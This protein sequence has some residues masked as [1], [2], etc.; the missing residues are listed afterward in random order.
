ME[1][2]IPI[3]QFDASN[4]KWGQPRPGPLRKT[5]TFSYE[6][7]KISFN[8][9]IVTLPPLRVVEVDME[10]NQ[11]ILEESNNNLLARLEQLQLKVNSELEEK[12]KQWLKDTK[13]PAVVKCPL[14]PWVKSNRITLYLSD[15]PE[16]LCFYT[17]E[18]NSVF[19]DKTVK[20]G[21]MILSTVKIHG[22]SLQM[23]DNDL[24]TG[25]SRIQHQILQLYKLSP[26]N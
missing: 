12:S 25:K 14:Q 18:G 19:S 24:W 17:Q 21:D 15:K 6:E 8:N 1:L 16:S 9:L 10:R 20:P 22:L 23:S 4:V 13:L 7:N 3:T 26:R 2:S 11:L 5:I